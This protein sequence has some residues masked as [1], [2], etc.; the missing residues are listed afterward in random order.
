MIKLFGIVLLGLAAWQLLATYRNFKQVRVAGNANTSALIGLG[1]GYSLFF[2]AILLV[3]G[4]A[5][6]AGIC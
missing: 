5:V 1:I 3:M 6:C 2:A 4:I